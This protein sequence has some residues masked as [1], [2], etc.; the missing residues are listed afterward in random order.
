M[1]NSKTWAALLALLVVLGRGAVLPAGVVEEG[2]AA[3][4]KEVVIKDMKFLVGGKEQPLTI[5][6]G[7]TVVFVNEDTMAHSAV[8]EDGG[9][10]F[11]TGLIR[12]VGR[13]K[14]VKFKRPTRGN[15][16]TYICGPHP[17]MKGSIIV[18]ARP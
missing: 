16:L 17:R 18:E 11:D 12:A 15:P 9:R 6:A 5:Q 1:A 14:P 13:S 4:P 10:S 3:K 7:D 2:R 8:S